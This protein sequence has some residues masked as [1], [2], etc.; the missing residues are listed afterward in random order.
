[1]R[2]FDLNLN[3]KRMLILHSVS[4]L[5]EFRL[6]K[7]LHNLKAVAP[8]ISNITAYNKYFVFS[9]KNT[10]LTKLDL[11]LLATILDASYNNE[12]VATGKL[13]LQIPRIGTISP[14]ASKALDI[15]HNCGLTAVAHVEFGTAFYLDG[16]FASDISDKIAHLLHDP[17]T[18]SLVLAEDDAR[19]LFSAKKEPT[20]SQIK[21]LELGRS[22]LEQANL[23]LGLA[24]NVDEINYLYDLF[25]KLKRNPSDVEL[26][27]FAQANS[28]HCR[29]KIFNSNFNIDGVD[30]EYSLFAMIKNT[31]K[32][33]PAGVLSAYKDNAAVIEGL[34]AHR[35]FPDANGEYQT[36]FEPLHILLKVETHNHPT[37]IAPF[38]GAA[39]GA[40]GEIRDEGATGIGAK[41]KAGLT[42]FSVSNLHIPN[43]IMD[44]EQPCSFAPN[45]ASALQIMLD[46][47]IGAAAFNNEFGRPNV[48]GYF[49]SFSAQIN[50]T[51]YGYHKPI[52]LAGGIGNIR[53]NH[54]NKK[55]LSAGDLLIVLGGPAMKIGLGGGAASSVASGTSS[56]ELDFASVQRGNPEMERR[57]QEVINACTN[58]ADLNPILF[59][60][61]VGAG[62]LCNALPELI[63]DGKVGG[64]F[65]LSKIPLAETGLSPL[66]IWCNEAQERYVLAIN[67]ANLAQFEAICKRERCPFAIVGTATIDAHLTLNDPI[68]N[69]KPVDLELKDLLGNLPKLKRNTNNVV[70][71]AAEFN[72]ANLNFSEALAKVLQHPTVASK[73]FLITIGDRSVGG[74][75]AR[76]PM[77]GEFQVPVADCAITMNDFS[78][79]S[80]EALAI[81][82]RT[83][84]AILDAKASAKMAVGEAITNIM[85][86]DIDAISDIKL[87]ANWMA[88]AN[89]KGEDAKLYEAV[90]AV[91]MELC[92]ALGISIPVGKDSL[93]MQ[94]SWRENEQNHT[95]TSPVSLIVT[96]CSKVNDVRK[97][98]TPQLQLTNDNSTGLIYIDLSAG[99]QRLGSSILAQ[100]YNQIGSIP[101]NLDNPEIMRDFVK[102]FSKLK[103]QNK[104]LAYHDRSDGG[105]IVTL[106]EMAFASNCGLSID[107]S[108]LASNHDHI[109]KA[110]FNEELGGVIQ[111]N[112][113]DIPEIINAFANTAINVVLIGTINNDDQIQIYH[114]SQL[115]FSEKRRKL[116]HLW[117]KVSLNIAKLRDNPIC[118]EQE[119]QAILAG[120]NLKLKHKPSFEPSIN[121]ATP[122]IKAGVRPQVA[123]L[124]E[125]GVNGQIEMA[126]AFDHAGFNAIDVHMS[127]IIAG[128]I[129]LVQFK[130]LVACGGFSYGDVLGAGRGWANTILF[131][132]YARDEFSAFFA[133]NDTFALGV[134]NGCQMFSYL[135]ELIAGSEFWPY[136][137]HNVS[138]QFEARISMVKI[139]NSPSILFTDME[140]S[141]LPI[142]VAHGEGLAKFNDAD[143][144]KLAKH[145]NL[146]AM[147]YVDNNNN[148]T[149]YYPHNPNGSVEGI[150]ALTNN[151]GRV[152]IMMPHPERVFHAAQ[153]TW[154][155]INHS[156][157]ARMFQN[158]RKWVD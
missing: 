100:C 136:F 81:G 155:N 87:C 3:L 46:A 35:F 77:I 33:N 50:D 124:R 80:G 9:A 138:G 41:P 36:N 120:N 108:D 75:V 107:I 126:A 148:P 118:A 53:A 6:T 146:V 74:L 111:V 8:N 55:Q 150:T 106:L 47:P 93:S 76:E 71:N 29:H 54:V 156:A 119:A 51:V 157:W 32:Q 86:S 58:L 72:P 64:V 153:H 26:M 43:F 7:L 147:Q 103:R 17:M 123:I 131:N 94:M 59:I 30:K 63:N 5:S 12:N 96:A 115:I 102:V 154:G 34:N 61:D 11:D 112:L 134:C 38:A 105:L 152:T 133:R 95:V 84:I 91:G 23:D 39:T 83:P 143:Q 73:N 109:N 65:D 135:R 85:A 88:A 149:S 28:E 128:K 137:K 113:A 48:C 13:F 122:Y 158:A 56:A 97:N 1:M 104:I 10:S 79:T 49:R 89:T 99:K 90:Y 121:I 116:H 68:F 114:S 4:S 110:L 57:A 19:Q 31:Y 132:K 69:N 2:T 139:T 18:Q 20:F 129:S 45:S 70:V 98:L 25:T 40:G 24:L 144:L 92:P 22:A 27:M 145:H 42:G 151:D 52:M 62:G 117:H 142:T 60:H 127:D 16:D 44:W 66:E 67:P 21:L 82:E 14:A 101:P 125:Q 37:A 140:N 130:G 141:V 15:L 78:G